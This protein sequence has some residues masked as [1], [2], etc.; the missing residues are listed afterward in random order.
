MPTTIELPDRIIVDPAITALRRQIRHWQ[1]VQDRA[2]LIAFM[3][4]AATS[5]VIT[6]AL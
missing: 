3:L 6:L 2:G 4:F 5:L 1:H